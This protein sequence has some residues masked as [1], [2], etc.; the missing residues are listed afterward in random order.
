M[1]FKIKI[2]IVTL[3]ILITTLVLNSVLSISSFEQNYIQSLIATY[4]MA[5][6]FLKRKIEQSLRFGK[7]LDKFMGMEKLFNKLI[8]QNPQISQIWIESLD[9]NILYSWKQDKLKDIINYNNG[10]FNFEKKGVTRTIRANGY[11]II[12]IPLK[13]ISQE[14]AGIIGISFPQKIVDSKVKTMLVHNF[15]ILWTSVLILSFCLIFVLAILIFQPLKKEIAE[16]SDIFDRNQPKDDVI[17]NMNSVDSKFDDQIQ[18]SAATALDIHQIKGEIELLKA[19]ISTFV[20]KSNLSL[21][22]IKSLKEEQNNLFQ[23]HDR[24]K[25][26]ELEL[27]N[28]INNKEH[29]Y[30]EKKELLLNKIVEESKHTRELISLMYNFCKGVEVSCLQDGFAKLSGKEQK[31]QFNEF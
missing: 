19:Y 9:G 18:D 27:E 13:N 15:N 12:Y 5:G 20:E 22:S 17:T 2:F 30:N 11:H 24:L 1:N 21:A 25:Q 26:C 29:N 23:Y 6:K 14:I 16:V 8:D 10:E 3:I 28:E 4:E 7:P 31:R